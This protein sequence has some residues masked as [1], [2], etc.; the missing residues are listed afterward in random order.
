MDHFKIEVKKE[1]NE[2]LEKNI[3][4]THEEWERIQSE[5]H[6]KKKKT[7]KFNPVYWTV[8]V[9]AASLFLF[10]SVTYIG[11]LNKG[12]SSSANF[13]IPGLFTNENLDKDLY[14][15][16]ELSIGVLGKIPE[17]YEKQISF[18]V[19]E[20]EQFTV[21]EIRKFDAIFVMK[22]SLSTAAEKQYTK[23]FTDSTIPFFFLDSNKG[24]Y[25]FIDENLEYEE[26]REIPYHDYYATGYLVTVDGEEM[27]WTYE[28]KNALS[29]IF[30]TIE[31]VSPKIVKSET[32]NK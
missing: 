15:G 26:A 16:K 2:F 25:P 32:M 17:T 1:V 13:S 11:D 18:Q 28:E 14:E 4:S 9:A 20:F 21:K 6:E 5:I 31:K 24:A 23:V 7:P 8:L 27:T 12:T 19:I 10:L 22:E 3:R 30:K 29:T